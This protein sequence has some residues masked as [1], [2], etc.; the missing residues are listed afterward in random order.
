MLKRILKIAGITLLTLTAIAFLVPL[1]FS[2][3]ITNLIKKEI[4][5]NINA[6]VDFS[7]VE[8]SIFRHF[9]RI[10]IN[11]R[12][13]SIVGLEGFSKDTLLSARSTDMAVNI[14]SVIKGSNIKVSGLYLESPRMHFLV[15][16]Q[17]KAN[18]D[19]A[20]ESESESVSDSSGSAFKL[21][22]KKYEI[23]NGY[24]LYKDESMGL[25]TELNE[26]DHEGSG[27]F[28]ED[29]FTLSTSTRTDAVNFTYAGIPYLVDTR[30]GID[31][32]IKIENT[33]NKYTFKTEDI[34]LNN[35]K[36]S[37]EGFFQIMTDSTYF[38]DIRFNTP[39]NE[40][41][42]ILSLIPVIYKKDFEKLQT[43]GKAA[44]NGFVKGV[45]S[46][47]Q[48]PAFDVNLQVTNGS[49]QYP[50]LPKPLK[51]VQLSVQA[52]NPDGKLDNMVIDIS[53]AHVEVGDIPF[54]FRFLFRQ[55]E[56]VR[57]VDAAAKGKLDLSQVGAFVKLDKDTKLAGTVLADA[58][59]KGSL[60]GIETQQ[61]N[62]NA[63]GYFN[64]RDLVYSSKDFKQPLKNVDVDLLIENFGGI[65]DNTIINIRKGHLELD[66]DPVDFTLQ[67]TNPFTTADFRGSAN[68]RFNLENIGQFMTMEPGTT[69]T[70]NVQGKVEFA[71]NKSAIDSSAYDKISIDGTARLTDIKYISKDYPTG[72][73]ISKAELGLSDWTAQLKSLTGNYLNSNF[74]AG[75]TLRD[76]A[77][78]MAGRETLKGDLHLTVDRMNMNEWIGTDTANTAS[79]TPSDPFLV[80]ADLDIRIT[81]KAGNVKY[82]KV[83]YENI[84]GALVV[85]EQSVK[86]QDVTAEALDGTIV[87]N[88]YYSTRVNKAQ[89]DIYLDYDIKNMDIQKAFL[90]Y[91]T[92]QSLMPIAQFLSGKLSSQLTM[93]GSLDGN[94][95]P[96]ISSLTGKGNL[97]L[98]E[99]VLKKF[100]PL[101]KIASTLQVSELKEIAIKD[102]KNYIEFTN[103]KVMVRPFDLKVKDIEMKI[104][105]MHGF[106]RSMD[107][108]VSM[109][110]PRKYLGDKGNN[111]ING[112]VTQAKDRGIPVTT[113]ETVNLNLKVG[114]SMNNPMV[115]AD[116][117]ET[118]GD[119]ADG[120]KQQAEDFAKQKL[121]TA[122]QVVKDTLTSVK[123]QL[124]D[125]LKKGVQSEL[126]KQFFGAD[127]TTKKDSPA[128]KK[129]TDI[130]KSLEGLLNRKKKKG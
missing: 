82:D 44:L 95:M 17:G 26:F 23:E 102:I 105:G 130:K 108:I 127:T 46:S 3:H 120:L 87:M 119:M 59:I 40:F 24:I 110:L 100:A 106:D 89:P 83:D 79:T 107:Y 51:N 76:L 125:D 124:T 54:D 8:L 128:T 80:P 21:G 50:D 116:L 92:V 14:I 9:P 34:L 2:N 58:F 15:D 121:D 123:N 75:G 22:L 112:L 68:G 20:K 63:G 1:V 66:K 86:L 64:I 39:A 29:V 18:W 5:N 38:M 111:L 57:Y 67:L 10:S 33:N 11:I 28:T 73:S 4:N 70:G 65:A 84:K 115:K 30:T 61:G 85:Q 98:I 12:D 93:N 56:T 103:G 88:G 104:G 47:T 81:A 97:L 126:K 43:S 118:A 16:A 129:T 90:A 42:D 49:F 91:N 74:N 19:V 96:V 69:M 27:D 77:G 78:Y 99:G 48:M 6:K 36:L 101:E 7:K 62:F 52:R 53:K 72:I 109:K 117:Q 35:L 32:D 31:A 37:A 122:K 55:P 71:G 13:L 113:G 41:K 114:G 45:Y 60:S 94:M 25:E